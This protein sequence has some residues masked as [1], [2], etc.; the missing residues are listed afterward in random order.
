M[1][2][3][4]VA[5]ERVFE[6]DPLVIIDVG[7]RGGVNTE[8]A[9]F[10]HQVRI[11]CFEPD[12]AECERLNAAST[13]N[14]VYIPTALGEKTGPATLFEARLN[15]S[16]GLYETRMD[17]FKR[18]VNWRNGEVVGKHV[19][20]VKSLQDAMRDH[21][22]PP[23][24][25]IKLDAEGAELDILKGGADVVSSERTLGVLS[26]L[27]LHREINGSPPFHQLDAFLQEHGFRLYDMTVNHHG[28][29]ALP[30][31]QIEDYRLP[32]G[33][34]FYAYTTHGQLQDGDAL[35]F[36]DF[37]GKLNLDPIRILKIC[38]LMEIY[39][40][41]DCA[42]ELIVANRGRLDPVVNSGKLLDLL[43]SSVTDTQTGYQAYID[44]Y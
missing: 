9:V 5:N 15:F 8:W 20:N 27:R 28:R 16:S 17:Y 13:G 24:D 22:I 12:A 31:R 36:R 19:T 25:F 35:Y 11:Y 33:E 26:E 37:Y 40:L 3:H 41:G 44:S 21:G 18:F 7:G 23:F 10:G 42:A 6:K 2:R 29:V 1:T 30:Y 39:S 38:C 34:R 32:S 43:T 14:V 4:L